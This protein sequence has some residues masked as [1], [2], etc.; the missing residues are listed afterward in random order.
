[1][2]DIFL[3]VISGVLIF[4]LQK[5]ISQLWISPLVKFKKC[6]ARIE[7]FL[8]RYASLCYFKYGKNNGMADYDIKYFQKEL[9]SMVSWMLV[10]YSILPKPEKW[11]LKKHYKINIRKAQTEMLT[12]VSVIG[13]MQGIENGKTRAEIA[14]ENI[15]KHLNFS[16]IKYKMADIF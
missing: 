14:I 9:R 16:E 6:L 11:W 1:M 8:N 2:S 13:T 12:L 3:A 4:T 7:A 15:A 5:L 10:T